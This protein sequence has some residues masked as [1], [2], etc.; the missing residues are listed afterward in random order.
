MCF[1]WVYKKAK[2]KMLKYWNFKWS[3]AFIQRLSKV[4]LFVYLV[5]ITGISYFKGYFK[6]LSPAISSVVPG[7]PNTIT[8]S[9]F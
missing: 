2:I 6:D 9:G 7:L 3:I 5:K 4:S 1:T 8:T